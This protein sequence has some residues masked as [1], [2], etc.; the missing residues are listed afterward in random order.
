[1]LS[2]CFPSTDEGIIQIITGLLPSTQYRFQ[3]R[4][5]A[6]TGDTCQIKSTDHGS[7]IP[8]AA[9][10]ET[11]QDTAF[12]TLQ[13]LV[14]TDATPTDITISLLG[15]DADDACTWDN[16]SFVQVTPAF[17]PPLPSVA[18]FQASNADHVI[19]NT[20]FTG[21]CVDLVNVEVT[22]PGPNYFAR[23]TGEVNW[24]AADGAI[25]QVQLWDGSAQVALS[26]FTPGSGSSDQAAFIHHVTAVPMVSGTTVTYTLRGL[27]VNAN[28][29]TTTP[30]G[31]AAFNSL[32]VV[33]FR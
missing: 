4:A 1:M 12:E 16:V 32:S 26:G 18:V 7:V 30:G 3:A 20:A 24:N 31:W 14:T 33:L 11:T 6:A 8:S 29:C 9:E 2:W 17:S 13:L 22:P 27:R 25:C 21:T 10:D 15:P 23:I 5:K 19:C 28:T